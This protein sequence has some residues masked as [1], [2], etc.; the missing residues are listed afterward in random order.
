MRR[1]FVS[2]ITMKLTDEVAEEVLSFR[3]KIELAKQLDK[4]GV[5]VIE[6]G[7][8]NE[9]KQDFLL[10]KSLAAAV[11]D[12]A[13]AVPVDVFNAQSIDS[14]WN[15]LAEAAHPRLQVS[16]PVSTVQ[17]EYLCHKKPEAIISMIRDVV[18]RCAAVCKD[19]EFI[20]EDF[21]RSD[22]SFLINT[23][24]TAVEAGATIITIFDS[25]GR[26]LENECYESTMW[27]RK[28][29]PENVRLAVW[30]SNEM[31]MADSCAIAAVRAGADE[32]KTS[33]YG[34]RTTSLKR[35]VK[36][37]NLKADVCC[38][39]CDVKVTEVGR[40]VEH[41]K[42]LCAVNQNNGSHTF[43]ANSLASHPNDGTLKLTI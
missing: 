3:Q 26:L 19:V 40:A 29:L 39:E 15:A 23:I 14:I 28:Q 27:I 36:I 18:G 9:Q 7:R 16:V 35:F 38:A 17:M 32:V 30:C 33:V 37:L 4:L 43:A 20:A 21:G 11:K 2:D 13:L 31:Y 8:V 24:Q 41:I 12:A 42:T 1:I 22:K 5:A 10:V 25:A 6:T 34:N